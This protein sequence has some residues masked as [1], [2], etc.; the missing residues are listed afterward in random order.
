MNNTPRGAERFRSP[1]GSIAGTSALAGVALGVVAIVAII[2]LLVRVLGILTFVVVA[3][4]AL[5]TNSGVA[6][7]IHRHEKRRRKRGRPGF[8]PHNAR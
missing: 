4:K 6:D 7:H 5:L 2:F 1:G 8:G 3:I